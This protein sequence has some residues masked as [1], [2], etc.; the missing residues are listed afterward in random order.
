[1]PVMQVM[2]AI[3]RIARLL[4]TD[5]DSG[6][7]PSIDMAESVLSGAEAIGAEADCTAIELLAGLAE[8]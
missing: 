4:E 8:P 1:M 2:E 3:I 7:G 5:G 6:S